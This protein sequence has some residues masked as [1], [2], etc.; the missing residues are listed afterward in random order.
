MFILL[1][2]LRKNPFKKDS[3]KTFQDYEESC[4]LSCSYLRI[5]DVFQGTE[6]D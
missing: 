5:D 2:K 1:F 6:R 3:F 4:A